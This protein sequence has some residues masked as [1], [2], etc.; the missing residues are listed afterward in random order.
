VPR[1]ST[2]LQA[3]LGS[4]AIAICNNPGKAHHLAQDLLVTQLVVLVLE[5]SFV[6]SLKTP[7]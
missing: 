3:K 2:S 1:F 6:D 4:H 5:V 7:I